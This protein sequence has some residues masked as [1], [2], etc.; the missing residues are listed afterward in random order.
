MAVEYID[1]PPRI[2]PE[3]PIGEVEIPQPP[4][5][6]DRGDQGIISML[7]P[8]VT[9]LGFVLVSGTG[10]V[11]FI[12][13]IG[14]AMVLSV[15]AAVY[16]SRRGRKE[17]AEKKVAYA[18]LLAEM[19]QEMSRSHG[20]QRIFYTHNYPD[21]QTLTEIASRK[22]TSRFGSRL[23]ERRPDDSDFGAIRLGMG[24]RPSSVVYRLSQSSSPLDETPLWKDA[25]KLADDSQVLTDVPIT[26]PLRPFSRENEPET[27]PDGENGSPRANVIARHSV[28]IFGKNPSNTADTAR[29]AL[30]HF[31]TFQSA[32]DSRLYVIGHPHAHANWQWAEWLPHCNVRGIGEDDSLEADK[33]RK[34]DQLCF[35]S[36]KDEVSSFWK[37]IKR[38]LDQRQLRLREMDEDD[39]K[40]GGD[41]TLPLLLVVVDLLGEM[42]ANSP[43]EEVASEAVV[44]MINQEGP[45]LGAAI[46]FLTNESS[47]IPSDCQAMV[48][49]AA[50]GEKV[51]FRYAEV[52]LNSTRYLGEADLMTANE[53]RHEIAAKIRRLDVRRSFGADLPRSVDMLQ[54]Q[55]MIESRRIDTVDKLT[56][57]ENWRRSILPE[58][59][60]W[61]SGPI[62][63]ISSKEERNLVFSAKEGGDGVHGMIAGT[64]GSGKSEL[65]LTL[66]ASLAAKYD[67]RIVNFVLVDFKGGAAFEPFRKLPHCVDI[68]T[69]LEANAVERMFVAIQAVMDERS[70]ILARSNAKDLV[71]YRRKVIP[72][73]GPD[74]PLPRTFP[75][76]FIIVDEF[77]EMIAA[78]PDYRT[79]FESITRLGRAFGVTLIL[80]TQRPAGVV[81]DQMRAN[82]KFRI[83][84]RVETPEDSKELLA[85]PDAAFLPNMG[86]RGYIQVGNDILTP[87]QVARVGGDYSDDRTVVLRDVIWLD[88]EV[89]PG[90]EATGD[91]PQ[92]S[93]T[94]VAE[95]LGLN[96]GEVPTTMLDWMVGISAIR[97]QRDGVPVQ[98]KPWPD[99]L[100]ANLSL[101]DPVDAR[102]LNTER[103]LGPD[104]TI[105]LNP[106]LDE[107]LNN[108][109]EKAIWPSV[110]WKA[111]APLS[112]EIGLLDN[113]YRAEQRLMTLDLSGGPAV[114]F[115]AAGRGKTTFLKTL[116]TGLAT[117]RSP[118]ELHM[119]ALD[120]GRA[121]LKAIKDLPHLGAA[122]DASEISRVDQ[123]MRMLRNFVN[124]RQDVL[125]KYNSLADYNAKNPKNLFP[126]ILVLIDNFAEFRE[127][128]EHLLPDLMALIRDGRAFGVNFVI[129]AGTPNDLGGK[130]YNLLTQRFTL[131][132]ADSGI[133]MDVV[134]RGAPNFDNV[135]GRGLVALQL[136]DEAVP[137]EFHIGIPGRPDALSDTDEVDGYQVIAQRMD[138]IWTALG[139]TRPAAELPRSIGFLEMFSLTEDRPIGRVGELPFAENWKRSMLAE[140]MEW[141]RAPVGLISSREVR[142]LVFSAKSDGDGVHGMI[143]GTTGSGKSE[144]LLTLIASMAVKYDPRIVNFVLVDFKGGAA[145]EPFKKLPHCVDIATNLQGNAV[146]RIFIAVKAELDRRAKLLA[147]GRV[148]DLVDYRKRVIPTLKPGDALPTTFPHLFIIVDEFAE[149]IAQNPEYKEQFESITRLGRAFGVTL[150]LATQRPAGMV[151]D[152]M[153]ANM[154]FRV[155]LRVETPEDS[156]E[157]LKRD[158]AARLP[159]LG[160]RGYIQ[161]GSGPLTEVQ[162]AWA[163]AEYTDNPVDPVYPTDEILAALGLQ[164]ENKPGLMIDWIVGAIAAEAKRQSVPVQRKPWP[165]PLPELL[166][167]NEPIDAAYI[168]AER[169]R[170]TGTLVIDPAVE[171]W[172]KNAKGE[173]LWK[174]WDWSAPLPLKAEIGIIDNPF[175]AE[176]RVLEFDLTSDPLVAFGAAG[177]GK[178]TFLKSLILSLAARRSPDELHVFALDFGRGGLKSI[179]TLPHCGATIDASQPDR[180]EQLFRMILG[181]MKERQDRLAAYASIEDYNAQKVDTPENMFPAILIVIDNFAEFQENYEHMLPDLIAMVRDGRSLGI[182]YAV[183]AGNPNELGGKLYNQLSQRV[184]FTLPDTT[185]YADI[186]GRGALSLVDTPGRGLINIEGQ[187]LEFQTATP[188]IAGEKDAY[189]RIAERM[190]KAWFDIGGKRPAAELPRSINVLDMYSMVYGKRIER[191]GDIPIAENWQ[192]SLQPENQEWL[193]A[194]FGLIS[195]REVRDLVFSAKADGDG[196]HGM[197]AGTTGSGKSELLLTLI[198]AMAI[199]YDP[200]I[201]NFVL[202]DY[203]GGA[204][205][206]PFKKL[207]HCVDIATNLQ[208]NAVE[209]IFIAMKAE[210]DRRAKLLADG[211]V[212]DLVDYRKRVIPRLKE[213]DPLP[214]TFPHLFIIVDEFAEMIMANPE[215]KAQFESIT[216]LG[217]AFG[218]TLILATQRPAGMVTDQMRANMKFRICL[219]V[220]TADDSK[221][222]LKRPDAATLPPLGGRG[223]IQVGGGALTEVQAAWAGGE[224]VADETE[225]VYTPQEM[226][227]ALGLTTDNQP[228]LM[229]DWIVAALAAEARRQGVPKQ[230]KPWPDPLPTLLP[231]N[232][233]IDATYIGEG[234][235]PKQLV[236]HPEVAA[237]VDN[238]E[239]A[240]I[241]E[242]KAAGQGLAA[243]TVMGVIDNPYLA[244]QRVLTIDLASDPLAIFGA[245]GRG[246]TTF[247]KSLAIGL[248]AT[249]SPADLHIFALDFGRGGL[250]ALKSLP[251]IGGIV[252]VNEEERVE[253]LLRMVRNTID[254]RQRKLQ[255]YDSIAEYNAANPNDRLPA[256]LV[257]IDNA[258]EF[259]ETYEGY[260]L[261]LINLV[262]DGRSFGVYFAMTAPLINDLPGKLFGI[263]SQRVTFTQ[264]DPSDYTTILGRGWS[265]F[266]DEPGRGLVIDLVG[267]RPQPL[268]FQT[269][270]P[271]AGDDTDFYRDLSDRMAKAWEAMVEADPGLMLR[272]AKPVEPLSETIDLHTVMLPLGV[273][274]ADL[275][276]PLGV[277]DLDREPTLIEF[278]AKGPNW[279]VV[280]PPVTGKTTTLRSLV[281]SLAHSYS[282]EQVAMVLVDPSDTSRQFF[283][284]GGSDGATL[285]D[286]PHV[287]AT[288]TTARQFDTMV[289]RL[290]AEFD[291]GVRAKLKSNKSSYTPQDNK[292]RSIFVIIDHY[293][294]A[295]VFNRTG[296]GLNGLSEIGKGKNLH[297]VVA[298]SL[299]IMRNSMDDLRRRAESSRYTLVLQDL[300]AVRYMG[301][302]GD[303]SVKGEL[304]LG[305]GFLVRSIH[306]N[307]VQ[308]CAPVVD[309]RDGRSAE[310]EL[311]EM[312][313]EIRRTYRAPARWSYHGSDLAALEK[314]IETAVP[315]DEEEEP[316]S[317]APPPAP[318]SP[319]PP[320]QSE[321]MAQLSELMAMQAQM[322]EQLKTTEIPDA[323]SFTSLTLEA[324]SEPSGKKKGTD[325][326]SAKKSRKKK[327]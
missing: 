200:R 38:E 248:A 275:V 313:A 81:T 286:L 146:E 294:D 72:R 321:A 170:K 229:I 99:P 93:A 261:D 297:F 167:M 240:P 288:V 198:A 109:E 259:K 88:E 131:A 23:W 192:H 293:D 9:I 289:K 211:R 129:T 60:E 301:V 55:S 62:G 174:P 144:L 325:G 101:T 316:P 298:G 311:T 317:S 33:N 324:D 219:R 149:M 100:P 245:A 127:S 69:N 283:N 233:A 113:P 228:G 207:P 26:V 6:Q 216:R 175:Q 118:A 295:E 34:L 265:S 171:G 110:D 269:A 159:P 41:I 252:E 27:S 14:L 31:V 111:P 312:I 305:R 117:T 95:A 209:R 44:G 195:S 121:G 58:N 94:E 86:G 45:A 2:Q 314:A 107:W 92:Y 19:R 267:G 96:P 47:K 223:Y 42:P 172:I 225:P 8:L 270:I 1:R 71:D 37:R 196:V 243:Q 128:F 236:L 48:E 189:A 162:A 188:I 80:S 181:Q 203:K 108:T 254:D 205:F 201:V 266:N 300:E 160:G 185:M 260:L 74:D 112:T 52:G 285:R 75:H 36:E 49:V 304:P 194:P 65:L 164:P 217:R 124:E 249:H 178:T 176:Q 222:L 307:L 25:K 141:L 309:G 140:N 64:T 255:A 278:K 135:P 197:I 16:T 84:L 199:R 154:K 4:D 246:K 180:V 206:E 263:L 116:M 87:I 82:M 268:E 67:P 7:L 5:E 256:V 247:L 173:A 187:P 29:A 56:I 279:L 138:R 104:R 40:G 242:E 218:A 148:G 291:E 35:S 326:A 315:L 169:A 302:R 271:I 327:G 231:M 91:V 277:N 274:P 125:A 15:G 24:S 177:R 103:T 119:F 132:Q 306:A 186:V 168:K 50:V 63:L 191:I 123:L 28:G 3:L 156:R 68:L 51:V 11:L 73:L 85:R 281:L 32:L 208:G 244:E 290:Q 77:A 166:P 57:E 133:Y 184:T 272:R 90:Q 120:F 238:S 147:D 214:K 12:I 83:C 190:E 292:T 17:L 179:A 30:A 79:K 193:R 153:R 310:E 232:Q 287:L 224:Y 318:A 226:L 284:Y 97:A 251:H 215:Y 10:N 145:F 296:L 250:K 220:E 303:F 143:A 115:G 323:T 258:S 239:V 151:T 152:Q 319:A 183:T 39:K 157:L 70:R 221:E 76:L 230:T 21:V 182:Y 13:P 322:S 105:V 213:D 136:G 106:A 114:I 253:R 161:V 122:I 126:E 276:V 257:L 46:I 134:G 212:G 142:S 20:V 204:A 165:E 237:W 53:A 282:P 280:G 66:I 150:I 210:L 89:L 299:G 241:W 320:E 235:T 22:E 139:G 78:N 262:R 227:E 130:L 59:S 137:V 234:R 264:V 102:Y 163:G 273:G 155:C 43:I 308:M 61:L 18:R 202:V 54:M 158:D 98:T